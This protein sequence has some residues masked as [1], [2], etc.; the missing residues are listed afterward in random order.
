MQ[1]G[2]TIE[3]KVGCFFPNFTQ[4]SRCEDLALFTVCI[5]WLCM[6]ISPSEGGVW[7]ENDLVCCCIKHYLLGLPGGPVVKNVPAR[8]RGHRF[9]PRTQKI[10]HAA[11]HLSCWAT[12]T[13]LMPQ[14]PCSTLRETTVVRSLHSNEDQEQ[15]IREKQLHLKH[16]PLNFCFK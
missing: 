16:Y 3:V 5:S 6:Y 2:Q 14:S 7:S 8:C 1:L 15:P 10:S 13:A 12:T 9:N 11:G 4:L